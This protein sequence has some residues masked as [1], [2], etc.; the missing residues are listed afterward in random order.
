MAHAR[1][2]VEPFDVGY[3]AGFEAEAQS[4]M[5][6]ECPIVED[7]GRFD[8]HTPTSHARPDRLAFVDGTMRTEARL[9]RTDTDGTTIGLA[10]SW[11]AGATLVDVNQERATVD[12]VEIGR[13]AIFGGGHRGELPPQPGGWR[14]VIDSIAGSDLAAARQRLQRH[15]RDA[16]GTIAETLLESGWITV[17][18]GPLHNIRRARTV[19][20]I[21]YIKTHHRSMLAAEHWAAVPQIAVGQRSSMFAIG[22][23]F[24]GA[25]ARVGDPGPW[26][27][28]WAGIVRLDVPS[29]AGR[30]A[31]LEAIDTAAGWLPQ[32]ASAP[33]RDPRAPVNLTTVAG[34]ERH[35]HHLQGDARL[36]LRAVRAAVLEMNESGD[37]S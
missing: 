20:V 28:A 4:P 8:I 23:D 12:R 29:G 11:G 25:Y 3:G 30:T 21:G 24:Y 14:W 2:G 10:G 22:D 7:D 1:Y 36:A 19:P 33:H 37:A 9:T 31:A 5:A 27:S 6:L 18:D 15:M 17:I 26:A 35:L 16:E 34:L 13:L 32:F